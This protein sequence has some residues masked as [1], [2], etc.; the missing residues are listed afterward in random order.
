[1]ALP[2]KIFEGGNQGEHKHQLPILCYL[3][4]INQYNIYFM[5]GRKQALLWLS[6][7]LIGSK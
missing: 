6:A 2:K 5:L 7:E 4:K 1:M 3:F